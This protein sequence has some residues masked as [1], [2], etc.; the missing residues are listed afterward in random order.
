MIKPQ[1][2]QLYNGTQRINNIEE[3]LSKDS[4]CN[5][6]SF[7]QDNSTYKSDCMRVFRGG[8]GG[9]EKRGE[10]ITKSVSPPPPPWDIF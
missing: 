9:E 7:R 3:R 8:G 10:K 4:K 6:V 2:I 5:C 1:E